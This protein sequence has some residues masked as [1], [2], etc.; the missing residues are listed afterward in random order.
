MPRMND[1]TKLVFAVEHI[2]HLQD[3]IEDNEAEPYLA[4]HLSSIKVEIERQ[5]E[6]QENKRSS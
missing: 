6:V 4:S 1:H 5:L 2:L 3:L